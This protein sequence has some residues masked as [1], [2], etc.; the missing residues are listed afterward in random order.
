MVDLTPEFSLTPEPSSERAMR[1]RRSQI[2]TDL[3]DRF[4][5]LTSDAIEQTLWQRR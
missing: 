1:L 3:C 5:C 4:F 2:Q